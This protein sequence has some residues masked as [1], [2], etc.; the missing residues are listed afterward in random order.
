MHCPGPAQ[1]PKPAG[2][3]VQGVKT[4]PARAPA[5]SPHSFPG[6][7]AVWAVLFCALL[8]EKGGGDPSC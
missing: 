2:D 1:C 4:A 7:S 6:G 5:L 8:G 3:T